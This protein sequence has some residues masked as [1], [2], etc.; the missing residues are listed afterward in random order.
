MADEASP[1]SP[2]V[3]TQRRLFALSGNRCAFTDCPMRLVDPTTGSNV[4]EVCHIKGEKPSAPR[5]DPNQDDK[6]R[7]GFDNLIVMCNVHHKIIDDTPERYPVELL[8]E[9]KQKHE[10]KQEGKEVVDDAMTEQ[11]VTARKLKVGIGPTRLGKQQLAQICLF[12]SGPGPVYV[13]Y[14]QVQWGPD[15]RKG[16]RMSR[17]T[18]RGKLPVRIEEQDAVEL[19]VEIGDNVEELTGIGVVDGDGH[20]WGAEDTALEVFKHQAIAHRL[21][22][23][24]IDQSNDS[25]L[26]DCKVEIGTTAIVEGPRPRLE[27]WLKNNSDVPIPVRSAELSWKYD[28]PRSMPSPAGKPKAVETEARVTLSRQSHSTIVAPDEKTTFVLNVDDSQA[29]FL[30]ELCRGDVKDGDIRVEIMTPKGCGWAGTMDEIP[31]AVRAV[32]QK[33]LEKMHAI[34]S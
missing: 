6:A 34:P 10:S 1:K 18:V 21:P 14:W 28:P 16:A 4:G 33:V 11:F 13:A 2:S 5:Y 7:H 25:S 23:L 24:P 15:G 8:T 30:V 32:A 19:L 29:C 9:L 31:G 20:L 12:N 26:E 27:V 3:K 17:S 22:P